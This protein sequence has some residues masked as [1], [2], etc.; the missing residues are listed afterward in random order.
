MKVIVIAGAAHA[1]I[2]SIGQ[3]FGETAI[4]WEDAG[5]GYQQGIIAGVTAY[6]ENP[7]LTPEIEHQKWLE[8]KLADGWVHGEAIDTTPKTHPLLL[9]FAELPVE[10]R[11]KATIL[12]AAVHALKDLPDVDDVDAAVAAAVAEALA[13]KPAGKAAAAVSSAQVLV[14]GGNIHVQYIG[15]K[16]AYT[17]HLY[18][19]GLSFEK[20]Q[21][22]GLPTE[23]ARKFLRHGDM[24]Q[25]AGEGAVVTEPVKP[26]DLDDTSKTLD[27]AAKRQKEDQDKENALIDLKQHVSN[28]TKNA[29][30]EYAMTNYRQKLDSRAS[31]ADLRQQ[32]TGMIDQYGAV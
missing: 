14:V 29:L 19:T 24:F 7:D 1:L 15:R 9:P 10:H 16:E 3:V 21:V 26:L 4:T 11:V 28:M 30:C 5:E 20:D 8:A 6:S 23:I 27:E 25:E 32:V 13:K 2:A 18:G 22:R 12:H 31:V 17:D